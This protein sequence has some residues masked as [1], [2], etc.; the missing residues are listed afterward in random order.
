MEFE[1]PIPT[2]VLEGL[3]AVRISGKTNMLDVPMVVKLALDMGYP[4]TALWVREHQA[5]YAVG[6]FRGFTATDR[7]TENALREMV[8][9]LLDAEGG[10]M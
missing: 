10:D 3:E 8:E 9:R 2:D 7:L 5:I 6:V 1:I 4:Q